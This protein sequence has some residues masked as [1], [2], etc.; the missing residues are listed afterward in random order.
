MPNTVE[1]KCHQHQLTKTY[2]HSPIS[3]ITQLRDMVCKFKDLKLNIDNFYQCPLCNQRNNRRKSQN[4]LDII[5]LT[6]IITKNNQYS[7]FKN[8]SKIEETISSRMK[9]MN[10]KKCSRIFQI[11][12]TILQSPKSSKSFGVQ[13]SLVILCLLI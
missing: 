6:I 10:I 7:G 12:L 4:L 8:S 3:E 11:H 1:A 9:Q 2:Y 5:N 13:I